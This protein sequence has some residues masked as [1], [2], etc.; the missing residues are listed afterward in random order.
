V[1]G[2]ASGGK[3]LKLTNRRAFVAGLAGDRGVRAKEREAILVIL[4]LGDGNL[5]SENGVALRAVGA[6]F[7]AVNVRVAIGAGFAHVS[8]D[9]SGMTFHAFD[10]FV[11]APKWVSGLDVVKFRNGADRPP[12][13]GCVA[14]FARNGQRTVR[15]FGVAPLCG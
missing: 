10:F 8:K 14:I 2:R 12:G 13:C 9:G 4:D 15:T 11:H 6:E 1:A 5:P 7:A 3:S